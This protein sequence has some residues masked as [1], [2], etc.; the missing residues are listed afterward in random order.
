MPYSDGPRL[1]R[2]HVTARERERGPRPELP[3]DDT[4]TVGHWLNLDGNQVI[5][6]GGPPSG[7]HSDIVHP[8]TP[9]AALEDLAVGVWYPVASFVNQDDAA[10]AAARAAKA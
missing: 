4:V 10:A 8:H 7:S 3:L 1:L 6:H 5:V 9:W 2:S